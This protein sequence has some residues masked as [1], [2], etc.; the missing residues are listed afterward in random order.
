MSRAG[1][2][3]AEQNVLGQVPVPP[4]DRW[5]RTMWKLPLLQSAPLLF[6]IASLVVGR[7]RD[8]NVRNVYIRDDPSDKA[9]Q[10]YVTG[11]VATVLRLQA[12]LLQVLPSSLV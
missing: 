2:C 6:L 11:Q 12:K 10:V 8:P 9:E 3:F 1:A 7:D 5:C 4:P